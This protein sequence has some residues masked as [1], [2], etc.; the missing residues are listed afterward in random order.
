MTIKRYIAVDDNTITNAY[1]PDLATRATGSNAGAADSVEIFSIFGQQN[2]ASV[3]KSRTIF[4]FPILTSDTT[5][6]SIQQDRTN[7]DIP[8]SGSVNFF[9]NLYNVR[10]DQTLPRNFTLVVAPL[11]QSWEEGSGVDLDNYKD[12]TY[13]GTGS[14][15]ANAAASTNWV[16][17]DEDGTDVSSPGGSILSASWN[18]SPVTRYNEFNYS[19]SFETGVE[20]LSVDITGLVEQWVLGTSQNNPAGTPG[21]TNYGVIVYLT[22]SQESSSV[23][24]YYTKRFS[25]RTSEYFFKRPCI[26]ARWDSSRKDHRGTFVVSSSNLSAADNL[27]TIYLYN[28]VRGQLKDLA[29]PSGD[30]SG[31]IYVTVHTSASDGD[32]SSRVQT[33]PYVDSIYQPI[34]GGKVSTGIY[35]ASMAIA[36]G[37]DIVYDRWW[38]ASD[39]EANDTNLVYYHTGSIKPDDFNTSA[40]FSMPDYVTTISNL[41][42]QY[43]YQELARF[44]LFT[45]LRNW[46]PTIYTI[47]STDIETSI[48]EDAYFRIYRVV[49]NHDVISYGTGSANHTKLSYDVSGSYFDLDMGLLEPG[50][51]YGIKFC[52]YLNGS[53]REQTEDFKFRVEKMIPNV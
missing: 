19:A 25:S 35:S 11:S 9:L 44:R 13:D 10:H 5:G 3:E 37:S 23:R 50:Y 18:G 46:N 8:K 31:S 6:S 45:R 28:Y 17:K 51:A 41:R 7:G 40:H 33:W 36:T 12:L 29:H 16:V 34:T 1:E 42:E 30:V 21:Y 32:G 38:T 14:N 26:E 48:V 43:H 53:Y 27:N 52:Y 39:G 2:S 47:A 20:D 22:A 24:S 15:W 4:K 49:D